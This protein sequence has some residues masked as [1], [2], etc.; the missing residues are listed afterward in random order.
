[1][2]K[3]L[4]KL[5]LLIC[6]FSLSSCI[7][8]HNKFEH[9]RDIDQLDSIKIYYIDS[10][11]N[12]YYNENED[13]FRHVETINDDRHVDLIN[14]LEGLEYKD[15]IPIFAPSDPNFNLHGFVIK[16]LYDT[17]DYQLVSNSG[18]V[19]TYDISSGYSNFI[20]I[21]EQEIWSNLLIKYIGEDLYNIYSTNK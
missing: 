15:I 7:T 4:S 19:Y 2:K 9:Y 13:L 16:I 17:G 14:D 21:V 18:A 8:I 1:M 11:Y 3:L 20:G 6:I 5:V 12:P 10:Y